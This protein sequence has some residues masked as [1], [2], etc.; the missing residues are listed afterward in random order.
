ME[1]FKKTL[2][3]TREW[4]VANINCC[5]GCPHHCRY[6]YARYDQV[7]K[8]AAVSAEQWKSCQINEEEVLK[9]QPHFEGQVMFPCTHDIVP[10]NLDAC[11][12][13]ITNLLKSKNSILL[14]SKPNIDCISTLCHHFQESKRSLLFRFTITANNNEILS[15]WEPGAP[16][17]KERLACLKLAWKKGFGTSVS[18]EPMLDA[19]TV[20]QMVEEL[21]HYVT[22]SIW[23]GKMNRINKRV[24]VDSQEMVAEIERIRVG[25]SESNIRRI[26]TALKNNPLM[27]WKES[28]KEVVGIRPLT[29]IGEDR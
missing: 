16:S 8:K 28:I 11:I 22:H 26:Y 23:L 17:Y 21:Q 2:R 3:G 19:S 6:C 15:F 13:V 14:V 4:A 18:V 24:E 7:V 25:Q 1:S 12:K 29:I 9:V 10:E 27:R 20:V 5:T